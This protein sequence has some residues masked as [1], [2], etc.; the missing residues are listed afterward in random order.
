[1]KLNQIAAT[2]HNTL[3]LAVRYGR[4]DPYIERSLPGGLQLIL[5]AQP[6]HQRTLTL[7][8]EG[9]PPSDTEVSVCAAAFGLSDIAEPVRAT[10]TQRHPT[11]GRKITYQVVHLRWIE[12]PAP[13]PATLFA[14]PIEGP[15][16]RSAP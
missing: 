5:S 16:W 10:L 3:E 15:D 4:P 6:G 8:R 1:M 2:M 7:R 9:V 11:T 14:A 13:K 12:R